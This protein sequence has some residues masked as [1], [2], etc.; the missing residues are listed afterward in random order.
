MTHPITILRCVEK[1][2]PWITFVYHTDYEIRTLSEKNQ[3]L[4]NACLS[5]FTVYYSGSLPNCEPRL[6]W[7]PRLPPR[8][9]A[10]YYNF[11]QFFPFSQFY[12]NSLVSLFYNLYCRLV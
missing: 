4:L 6:L 7:E 5:L 8:G 10:N 2:L 1:H 3:I 12:F 9:A 11:S